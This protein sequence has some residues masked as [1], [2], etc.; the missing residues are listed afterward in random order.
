MSKLMPRLSPQV[1]PDFALQHAG[2]WRRLQAER[3]FRLEQLAALDAELA[4]RQGR[5]S[6]QLALRMAATT[7]LNE[8]DAALLRIAEGEYGRCV[9]CTRPIP[10]ARLDVMPSVPRC[11]RCH[12]N[13][14]TC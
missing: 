8:I 2:R 4:G 5:G 1:L 14:Q 7:A 12:F 11:M 6:V 10:A 9:S 3:R 13:E